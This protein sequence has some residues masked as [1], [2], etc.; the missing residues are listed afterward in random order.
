MFKKMME[1]K[2]KLYGIKVIY[3]NEAYTSGTSFLD[4]EQP[5][6]KFYTKVRRVNR[7]LFVS[8][9]R[10]LINAD[11]NASLQ[12]I[13]KYEIIENRR[14]QR[15]MKKGLI[16]CFESNLKWKKIA[17]NIERVCVA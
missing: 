16:S 2:A 1:Y 11:V 6:K 4:N 15:R 7:G 12:I 8:N 3:V 17:S 14:K 10:I 13:K 9:N 5:D